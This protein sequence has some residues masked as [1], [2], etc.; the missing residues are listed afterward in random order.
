MS[1]ERLLPSNVITLTADFGDRFAQAQ[2]E[3]AVFAINPRARFVSLTN[4]VKPFC[5][6]EGAFLLAKSYRFSPRGS[7][8]IGVVDPGVGS[9]RRGLLIGTENYWFIGPDNGLLYPAAVDDGVKEV[10]ALDEE[11]LNSRGLNTF[12]GRDVFAPAAARLSLG[13]QPLNFAL[14]IDPE[15]IVPYCFEP[16]QVAHIDPYGNVKLTSLPPDL[17]PGDGVSIRFATNREVVVSYRR[18][19]ADVAEGELVAYT[20]SHG[21]LE[22]AINRGFA[23][24]ALPVDI[25]EILQVER[26]AAVPAV[27][28]RGF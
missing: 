13:E 10:F 18:T 1:K 19:F 9:N 6:L 4:E 25:G 26:L 7:I 12:H 20:G 28:E 8:H 22:L 14:P 16:H 24:K 15:T 17:K 23:A 11:K 5:I 2:V 3:L 21:T 27:L